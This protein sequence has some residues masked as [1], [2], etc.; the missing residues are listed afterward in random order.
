MDAHTGAQNQF[1]VANQPRGQRMSNYSI[2]FALANVPISVY[3][4]FNVGRVLVLS[5]PPAT[6]PVD[7]LHRM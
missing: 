6:A 5:A 2:T 7:R 3:R 4:R 1:V